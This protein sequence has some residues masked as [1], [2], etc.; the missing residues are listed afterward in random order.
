MADFEQKHVWEY[1][2][3]ITWK[4]IF[5]QCLWFTP[6]LVG[7]LIA[8]RYID[9]PYAFKILL[10]CVAATLLQCTFMG[11]NI[12]H[13]FT[14][15]QR[16]ACTRGAVIVPVS[17]WSHVETELPYH[18]IHAITVCAG[19]RSGYNLVLHHTD[20]EYWIDATMLHPNALAEVHAQVNA[21]VAEWRCANG[22]PVD[23]ALLPP[24]QE[25]VSA[26]LK[27]LV[28]G[29]C[30]VLGLLFV[31]NFGKQI[32]KNAES[33]DWIF[34]AFFWAIGRSVGLCALHA[35]RNHRQEIALYRE[36][37]REYHTEVR[38]KVS[39]LNDATGNCNQ[40]AH[41]LAASAGTRFNFR[42]LIALA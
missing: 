6:Y 42:V 8:G 1:A 14:Y 22:L 17:H 41:H 30:F 38:T 24:R 25:R 18:R 11:L 16:I 12:A 3:R 29:M 15:R 23:P 35:E 33:S 34:A 5:R 13:R 40:T 7:M 21:R 31:L 28:A 2:Y 36:Q 9:D 39:R 20:G 4:R 19:G 10:I 37:V 26:V 27:A 32:F